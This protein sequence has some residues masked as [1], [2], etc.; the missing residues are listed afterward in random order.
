MKIF[1]VRVPIFENDIVVV[2]DCDVNEA[3]A[4]VYD[5]EGLRTVVEFIDGLGC[6]IIKGGDSNI[7]VWVRD[8]KETASTVFHELV[9]VAFG[10]CDQ[11]GMQRDEELVAYLMGWLKGAIADT[12]FFGEEDHDDL[13]DL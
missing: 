10:I 3:N 6:C 8:P 9:H 4:A 7:Y 12:I 11:R 5:L 1:T 13:E 2:H